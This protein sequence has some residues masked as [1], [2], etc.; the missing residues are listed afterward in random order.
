MWKRKLAQ[1]LLV[2]VSAVALVLWFAR[3]SSL[4]RQQFN[5]IKVGMSRAQVEAILGPP[6]DYRS[7][8]SESDGS[9]RQPGDRFGDFGGGGSESWDTDT[10]IASVE[11]DSSQNVCGGHFWSTKRSRDDLAYNVA[12]RFIH[13]WAKWVL[14]IPFPKDRPR[15]KG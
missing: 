8:E 9:P 11:F 3:P 12:W 13:R 6:G 14:E 7:A 15:T 10:G 1:W 2:T 4:T 5:R